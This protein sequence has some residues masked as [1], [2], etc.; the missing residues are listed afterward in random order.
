MEF[1]DWIICEEESSDEQGG[2]S[3]KKFAG[4]FW[5]LLYPSSPGDFPQSSSNPRGH[6]WL[7]WRLR[8]GLDLG[9]V[10]HNID[11]EELQQRQY[12]SIESLSAPDGGDDFWKHRDDGD[13]PNT[14]IVNNLD[15]VWIGD[16]KTSKDSKPIDGYN[17]DKTFGPHELW[18]F[19]SDKEKILRDRFGDEASGK[20]PEVPNDFDEPWTKKYESNINRDNSMTFLQKYEAYINEYGGGGGAATSAMHGGIQDLPGSTINNGMPV[21]SRIMAT[22]RVKEKKKGDKDG[23]DTPEEMY[24]FKNWLDKKRS[25]ESGQ[26]DIHNKRRGGPLWVPRVYT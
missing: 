8:R 5:D 17:F 16:G 24:G 15:L 14:K 23:E 19:Y 4:I 18:P 10:L 1:R 3:R 2:S 12:T 25:R 21:R 22:D 13:E 20:W 7:Q 9:R 11:N 6:L 26:K